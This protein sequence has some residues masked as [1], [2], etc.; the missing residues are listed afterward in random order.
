MSVFNF[1]KK[2]SKE[3]NSNK[4]EAYLENRINFE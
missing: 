2:I 4:K 1:L 3:S